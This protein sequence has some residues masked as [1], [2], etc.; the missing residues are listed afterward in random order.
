M[1]HR[2]ADLAILATV[3]FA[4]ATISANAD[5]VKNIESLCMGPGLMRQ[6]GS[7][8]MRC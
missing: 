4:W 7:P 1:G 6:G 2:K 5:P 3:L 8:S